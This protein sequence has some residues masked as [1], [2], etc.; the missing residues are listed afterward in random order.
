MNRK[1]TRRKQSRKHDNFKRARFLARG[2]NFEALEQRQLLAVT[3][4][5]SGSTVEFDGDAND[6][7]YLT[8]IASGSDQVLAYNT[9]GSTTYTPLPSLITSDGL[10]ITTD[11]DITTTFLRDLQ[12]PGADLLVT[13][14]NI[15]DVQAGSTISTRVIASGTSSIAGHA[16]DLSTGSSGNI[17]LAAPRIDVNLGAMLLTQVEV[18]SAF[19]AGSIDITADQSGDEQDLGSELASTITLDGAI[20]RGGDITIK[21]N[22]DLNEEFGEGGFDSNLIEGLSVLG[23]SVEPKAD[24]TITVNGGSIDAANLTLDADA[25]VTAEIRVFTIFVGVA[26]ADRVDPTAEIYIGGNA[27][28]EATGNV[29]IDSSA[30]AV[31]DV[32]AERHKSLTG[33]IGLFSEKV[34]IAIAYV[35]SEI[36]SRA[37]L[38]AGSSIVAGGDVLVQATADKTADVKTVSNSGRK[39]VFGTSLSISLATSTVEAKVDGDITAGGDIDILAR[40]DSEKNDTFA[41]SIVGKTSLQNA[42]ED[43]EKGSAAP[44]LL[45]KLFGKAVGSRFEKYF[46]KTRS[47]FD[48]KFGVSAAWAW[49]DQVNDVTARIGPGAEVTSSTGSIQ[50]DATSSDMPETASISIVISDP[51]AK[52]VRENGLSAAVSVGQFENNAEAYIG[53]GAIVTAAQGNLLINSR[54]EIPWEQQW[55][56]WEGVET[57]TDKLNFNLGIQNGLFTSWAEAY[58]FGKK[59]SFGG[60]INLLLIN[61]TSEAYIG[62]GAVVNVGFD[63]SVIAT[64]ENDTINFAGQFLFAFLGFGAVAGGTGVGGSVIVLDYANGTTATI[65]DSAVVNTGSLLVMARSDERSINI[66]T[67]GGN[68]DKF[69]FNGAA[70]ALFVDNQTRARIDDGAKITTGTELVKVPIDFDSVTPGGNTLF[71]DV[72]QFYPGEEYDTDSD[73]NPLTRVNVD[74]DTITLPYDHGLTTGQAVMYFRGEDSV[75]IGG[76]LDRNRYFAVVNDENTLQLQEDPDA[77]DPVDLNLDST[78]GVGHTLFPGF[79]P[80]A[81]DVIDDTTKQIDVGY[82]HSLVDGQ[83]VTY[84]NKKENRTASDDIPG[85]VSGTRYVVD[86]VDNTTFKLIRELDEQAYFADPANNQDLVID[87]STPSVDVGL[88]HFMVPLTSSTSDPVD[89]DPEL[90][91]AFALIDDTTNQI[92]TTLAHGLV[93]EQQVTYSNN[94]PTESEDIPGLVSGTRYVVDVV[95]VKTFK[96]LPQLDALIQQAYFDDPDSNQYLVVDISPPS[97]GVDL[98]HSLVLTPS[99]SDPTDV[100]PAVTLSNTLAS[101]DSND[102]GEI[103][104]EDESIVAVEP[105]RYVTNLSLLVL[106]DDNAGLYSGTGA[107]SKGRNIGVGVAASIKDIRRTTEALIS[108]GLLV[109]LTEDGVSAP[110]VGVDNQDEIFL[111]YDHGLSQGDQV[112]YSSGGDFVIGGLQDGET[113]FVNTVSDSD[114]S[115]DPTLKLARTAAEASE[116]SDTFFSPSDVTDAL[117]KEIIDLGYVHGFQIGDAVRY[118]SGSGSSIGGLVDG[119]VYYVIPISST[120]IAL[121]EFPGEGL[122]TFNTVFDPAASVDGDEILFNY[123]Q[124]FVSGQAVRYTAGGGTP[125]GDLVDGE[126]YYVEVVDE[127]AIELQDSNGDTISLNSGTGATGRLHTLNPG[128]TLNSTDV[129]SIT[130]VIDLSYLHEYENGDPI[131]YRADGT[132]LTGLNDGQVY[133]VI[134]DGEDSI[135][136]AKTQA[137]ADEGKWRFFE[138]VTDV[139][140]SIIS[141]GVPLGYQDGDPLVYSTS[142]Y[143]ATDASP[144]VSPL[145]YLDTATNQFVEMAEG[146]TF[147]ALPIDSGKTITE[148]DGSTAPLSVSMQLS[149]TPNGT[150]LLLDASSAEGVHGFRLGNVRLDIGVATAGEAHYFQQYKRFDLDATQGSG[151][152]HSLRLALDPSAAVQATHGLGRVFDPSAAVDSD[153][154]EIDLGFDHGFVTGDAVVYSSGGLGNEIGG[155]GSG[156]V[157]YVVVV[158]D[159]TIQL[160]QSQPEAFVTEPQIVDLDASVASGIDHGFGRVFR[161]QVVVDS[162]QNTIDFGRIHS[163][164]SGDQVLYDAGDGAAIGGLTDARTYFVIDVDSTTIQLA[165]TLADATAASPVAIDLDG[166]VATGADQSFIDPQGDGFIVTGGNALVAANN[167]GEIFSLSLAA[168]I[169]TK[170]RS[171]SLQ[172]GAVTNF[173]ASSDIGNDEAKPKYGFA[174]AGDF[175]FN[176]IVDTTNAFVDG[177]TLQANS[178]TVYARNNSLIGSGSGAIAIATS[179]GKSVGIA[180]SFTVNVIQNTTQARISD[181]LVT[182]VEDVSVDAETSGQIFAISISGASVAG[183]FALAGSV[184]INTIDIDTSA[185]IGDQSEILAGGDVIVNAK[186]EPIIIAVAGAIAANFEAKKF[187]GSYEKSSSTQLSVGASISVNTIT[188]DT[189]AVAFI[190]D[191]D[192]EADNVNLIATTNSNIISVGIALAAAIGRQDTKLAMAAAIS[193]GINTADLRTRAYIRNKKSTGILGRNGVKVIADNTATIRSI[194]GAAAVASVT[195]GTSVGVGISFALSNIHADIEAYVSDTTIVADQLVIESNSDGTIQSLGVAGSVANTFAL[196]G[197]VSINWISQNVSTY[198]EDSN[199]TVNGT[200]G[201]VTLEANNTALIQAISGGAAKASDPGGSSVGAALSLNII[202]ASTSATIDGSMVTASDGNVIV[203][204]ISDGQILSIAAGVATA[205]NVA[206]AGSLALAV[207]ASDVQA[208]ITNSTVDADRNLYV[209]ADQDGQISSFGGAIAFSTTSSGIGGALSVNVITNNTLAFIEDSTVYARA[210]GFE[211]QSIPVWNDK[212]VESSQTKRGLFVIASSTQGLQLASGSVG[213]TT[214]AAAGVGVNLAP[215]FMFDTTKAYIDNSNV[216]DAGDTGGDVIV[217][218]HQETE[219]F[220]LVGAGGMSTAGV[221]VGIAAEGIFVSNDTQAWISDDDLSDTTGNGRAAIY[222]GGDVDVSTATRETQISIVIGVAVSTAFAGAGAVDYTGFSNTNR[223]SITEVDVF[224][225]NNL[226]VT[227]S[228]YLSTL[229]AAGGVNASFTGAAGGGSFV[230]VE[231]SNVTE[232]IIA[233]ANTNAGGET[234]V[235]AKSKVDIDSGAVML[236]GS[237]TISVQGSFVFYFSETDTR[238]IIEGGGSRAAVVNADPDYETNS[239]TVTV[240]AEDDTTVSHLVGA[241]GGSLVFSL[242]GAL[243]IIDIQNTVDA[244]I[245]S[246]SSISAVDD[247]TVEA[248]SIKDIFSGAGSLSASLVGISG[249]FIVASVGTGLSAAG[250]SEIGNEPIKSVNDALDSAFDSTGMADSRTPLEVRDRLDS[251][252]VSVDLVGSVNR[253]TQDVA[254][255]I[256]E[257]AES[258]QPRRSMSIRVQGRLPWA[259]VLPALQPLSS[260]PI[261]PPK[262]SSPV[263]EA[264]AAHRP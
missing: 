214:G 121:N 66:A 196:A 258:R 179:T 136:L 15:I 119:E 44:A 238:A 232:A 209:Q 139:T 206:V 227:A 102:D 199:V 169:V 122:D 1:R 222:S 51:T 48:S 95:N 236:G 250:V 65:K 50:V 216:N 223:A 208:S 30:V 61:G 69:A 45:S 162:Q 73:D 189:G 24:A 158:N 120:T 39:G 177:T 57:I 144:T 175:T 62:E 186:E 245:G 84:F 217:R 153:T 77:T 218:A 147:Y 167:G 231:N 152:D 46:K 37:V 31:V 241:A 88:S 92:E 191:S 103:N 79:D 221:G 254:A 68:A 224:A 180:G 4:I 41:T 83:R 142:A 145:K 35:N 6:S 127:N 38:E 141:M 252:S 242:A 197:Q 159:T 55:W 157:F 94:S 257:G 53:A 173:E 183:F 23:G 172:S 134:I 104:T 27:Q 229:E 140:D 264:V 52:N 17:S 151:V 135:A 200:G 165:L 174:I 149:L 170:S 182:T 106:A 251:T 76:L 26:V 33:G 42:I 21:A 11:S 7:L 90:L 146:Q 14:A 97:G 110:G 193:V 211:S 133:Y 168:S 124:E 213:A 187:D 164:Q 226:S 60:S 108:T 59:R 239:Q 244:H 126:T 192:V 47:D 181:S 163:Y 253:S 261:P 143:Y 235:E 234:L 93:D 20:L 166:T 63:T 85:L 220:T 125:F 117:G 131:L 3:P 132:P 101:L 40:F 201:D 184:S 240:F 155:L 2:L 58:A 74:D 81:T 138:P 80:R 54:T 29:S 75:N 98:A 116:A 19:T 91:L 87:I 160:V 115:G 118:R 190:E 22:A 96:L 70:T 247:V 34:N 89:P 99:T 202:V 188:S 56:K 148:Q 150:A 185:G 249:S 178:L 212:G 82:D 203:K 237:A 215:T 12:V 243:S 156:N 198:I 8:T 207:I 233:S 43:F 67:Q 107:M 113:Y 137:A 105:G 130:D 260:M 204:S 248:N 78:E 25:K 225:D 114:S 112:T 263:M 49:A 161:P 28:I 72:P 262:L 194:A 228:D 128:T 86:V 256:D 64:N 18:G 10:E 16:T 255:F 100:I 9:D 246:E 210:N 176:F 195:S 5:I 129:D 13:A 32:S 123:E 171:A 205:G 219:L 259:R 71:S 36:T 109:Q 154:D 230:V 111:G